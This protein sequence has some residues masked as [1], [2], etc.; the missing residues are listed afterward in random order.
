MNP[1]LKQLL[2]EVWALKSVCEDLEARSISKPD[3]LTIASVH[4]DLQRSTVRLM[5]VRDKRKRKSADT[6]V[7]LFAAESAGGSLVTL[8]GLGRTASDE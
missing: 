2:D 4:R 7:T 3:T 8:P 1:E 5:A 6:G